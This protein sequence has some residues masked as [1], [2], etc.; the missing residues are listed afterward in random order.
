MKKKHKVRVEVTGLLSADGTVEIKAQRFSIPL[1]CLQDDPP[2][3]ADEST[4][5]FCKEPA[6]V[7]T[8]LTASRLKEEHG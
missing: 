8:C 2:R 3:A 7:G 5:L 6:V 1:D 4:Y